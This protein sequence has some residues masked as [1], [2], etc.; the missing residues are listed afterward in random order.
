MEAEIEREQGRKYVRLRASANR[1]GHTLSI[2]ATAA[3]TWPLPHT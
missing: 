1:D 2:L 3:L